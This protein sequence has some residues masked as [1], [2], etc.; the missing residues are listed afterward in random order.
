MMSD[1]MYCA[2][3]RGVNINGRTLRMA[4]VC[5]AFRQAGVT[6]VSSILA[7][8]NICFGSLEKRPDLR[9]R[10]QK[11]LLDRFGMDVPLVIASAADVRQTVA[12][13]PWPAEAGVQRYAF[14]T[15]P[16]AAEQLWQAWQ[17]V[18]PADGE[19]ASLVD[20]RFYWRCLKGRTLDSGF[21][22]AMG[23]KRFREI[24]TSRNLNT[25]EKVAARLGAG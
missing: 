1:P 22:K 9:A 24:S 10:L 23:D 12:D 25:V 5:D 2:F 7:S 3:L 17:D 11:A 8:G 20:G 16:G 4:E 14:F 18:T 19:T 21:S 6:D 13:A 15:E